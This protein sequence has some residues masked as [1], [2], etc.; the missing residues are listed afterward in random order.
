MDPNGPK[1]MR[2]HV[3]DPW[4]LLFIHYSG[5][6]SHLSEGHPS[7]AGHYSIQEA[8]L[9]RRLIMALLVF[10]PDLDLMDRMGQS[11]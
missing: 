2:P 8:K 1:L 10:E 7:F 5:C 11:L 9:T 6:S 3:K 4:E